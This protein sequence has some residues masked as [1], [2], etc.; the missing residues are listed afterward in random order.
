MRIPSTP[1]PGMSAQ[2]APFFH[3]RLKGKII[4]RY[5][6]FQVSS[7]FAHFGRAL[8]SRRRF[9]TGSSRWLKSSSTFAHSQIWLLGMT[10]FFRCQK[11]SNPE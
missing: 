5:L 10:P 11:C 7:K 8:T 1:P 6:H 4:S 9:H 3:M 2:D